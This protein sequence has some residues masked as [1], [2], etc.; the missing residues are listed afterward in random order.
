[1]ASRPISSSPAIRT[2]GGQDWWSAADTAEL[3]P[4]GG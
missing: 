2:N 3:L 1:L 4:D